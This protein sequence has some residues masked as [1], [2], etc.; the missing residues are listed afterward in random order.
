MTLTPCAKPGTA[1]KNK[2]G[3]WRDKK[4]NIDKEKCIGCAQC[5]MHCPEGAI[6]VKNGKAEI[7][8]DYCKGCGICEKVCPVKAISMK[9]E[10]K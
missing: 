2:T 1:S 3:S 4:P 6:D 9:K 5:A 8:Y 10:E 7:D